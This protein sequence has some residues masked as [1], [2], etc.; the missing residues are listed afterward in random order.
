MI[1]CLPWEPDKG[2]YSPT[3]TDYVLNVAPI[4]NGYGPFNDLSEISDALGK[5]CY[6]A[7]YYRA[8]DGSFGLVAGSQTTLYK[9][10]T[11][12]GSWDDI[13][14][15]SAPYNVPDGQLWQFER[16]GPGLYATNLND[17]LQVYD[18]DGGSAFADVAGSPPQAKYIR[19]I[20]DFLFLLYLK[21]GADE[22]PTTWRHSGLNDAETWTVGT[23]RCDQQFIPSGDEIVGALSFGGGGRVFQR[24]AL[25]SVTFNP[26]GQFTFTMDIIDGAK[27]CVAP[28]SIVQLSRSTYIY[29]AEDGWYL[30]DE[31]TPIGRERIDQTFFKTVDLDKLD[32]VQAIADPYRKRALVRFQNGSGDHVMWL[33]D[34]QL[35]KWTPTDIAAQFLLSVVTAG[36]T[37]EELDAFGTLETL[38][39]SMDSRIWKGGRPT[40]GAFKTDGK[41]YSFTGD[42]AAAVIRTPQMEMVS[43]SRAFLSGLRAVSDVP[44]DGYTLKIGTADFHGQA[45][46]WGSAVTPSTRTGMTPFR[47]SG[48][49]HAVE[50]DIEAGAIWEHVHGF[51]E[52]GFVRPE[53]QQ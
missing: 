43:G 2:P 9:Y 49:L 34:W 11:A 15:P 26:G 53:G 45:A 16:F 7:T 17:A 48:R 32:Q 21:V 36:Y 12:S 4:A 10:N 35:D 27:G 37:L 44:V 25:R 13:S 28:Y 47:R 38:T 5:D 51:D 18:V 14:G 42:A 1:P 46:T 50:M 8:S 23:K 22:L 29:L 40:V 33:Y 39:A 24:N 6:G 3:S 31:A 41:M 20:G 30:N 19:A 52:T